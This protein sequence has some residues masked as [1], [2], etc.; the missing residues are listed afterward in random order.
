MTAAVLVAFFGVST[1]DLARR[2]T[3]GRA[4]A[5]AALLW[6]SLVTMSVQSHNPFLYLRF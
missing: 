3:T 2:I 6:A 5:V 4:V 1:W